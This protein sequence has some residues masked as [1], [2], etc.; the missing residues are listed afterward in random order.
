MRIG[1]LGGGVRN[2]VNRVATLANQTVISVA[3]T[4]LSRAG[5]TV[6]ITSLISN[7]MAFGQGKDTLPRLRMALSGRDGMRLRR[8]EVVPAAAEATPRFDYES[9]LAEFAAEQPS[10]PPRTDDISRVSLDMEIERSGGLG[11]R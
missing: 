4:G 5:K 10:W 8:V 3:V 9:K 11:N 6:F 7:L 2:V 1:R